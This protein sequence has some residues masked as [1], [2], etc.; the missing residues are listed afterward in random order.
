M[1]EL[2]DALP[3]AY[4]SGRRDLIARP[5]SLLWGRRAGVG[6]CGETPQVVS[7]GRARHPEA[8]RD[9]VGPRSLPAQPRHL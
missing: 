1:Q 9:V 7:N 4:V 2:R 6:H 8:A 3:R 5:N